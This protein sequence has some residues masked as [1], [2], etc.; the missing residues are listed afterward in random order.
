[1]HPFQILESIY[2][3]HG[4]H[5][6]RMAETL[7]NL[8]V[9]RED[10]DLLSLTP[11]HFPANRIAVERE[12]LGMPAVQALLHWKLPPPPPAW[13]T[14]EIIVKMFDLALSD[15]YDDNTGD[16]PTTGSALVLPA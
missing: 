5:V 11:W 9:P 1:M 14:P 6:S 3:E 13:L 8:D 2:H 4:C 15:E 10:V 12:R 7:V 16:E